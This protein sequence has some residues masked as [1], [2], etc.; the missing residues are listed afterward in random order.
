MAKLKRMLTLTG[1]TNNTIIQRQKYHSYCIKP[2]KYS[3]FERP[4]NR[5]SCQLARKIILGFSYLSF[6]FEES[7]F[8]HFITEDMKHLVCLWVYTGE[9]FCACANNLLLRNCYFS[10]FLNNLKLFFDYFPIFTNGW[11]AFHFL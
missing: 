9:I 8:I 5:R 11:T 2:D 3:I 7:F 1:D 6:N 10:L 4:K